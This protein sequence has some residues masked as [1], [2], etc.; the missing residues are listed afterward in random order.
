MS[1]CFNLFLTIVAPFSAGLL[2]GG[3]KCEGVD[4]TLDDKVVEFFL[5]VAEVCGMQPCCHYSVTIVKVLLQAEVVTAGGFPFAYGFAPLAVVAE[6]LDVAAHEFPYS[7]RDGVL[8][9]HRI[10]YE[11]LGVEVVCRADGLFMVA[12]TSRPLRL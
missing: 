1:S 8:G 6:N 12:S 7:L 4:D 2:L 10:G 5:V 9:N 11:L 3:S